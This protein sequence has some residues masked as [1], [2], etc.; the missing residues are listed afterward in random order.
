VSFTVAP[1][2][3]LALVGH[4]GA[5]KTTVVSL[6]L[7]FYDP[8]RGTI[9]IDGVDVRD[10]PVAELRATLAYVQQDIFLFAGDVASNIRL[11]MPLSDDDVARAAA[12]VGADR[13]IRRLPAGY[14]QE[15][16]ERGASVSVGERQLL[17][18][19]RAIAADPAL[20]VL[21]EATSAVDSELEAHIQLALAELMQGRTTI[22]IAHRLSTIV[23]ATEILVLHHGEVRERGTHASL[24]AAGGLYERLYRLQAGEL[25]R[26]ARGAA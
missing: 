4:T 24:L 21:D 26:P 18:F 14:K 22:A 19:A 12:R 23:A 16:G 8:Q 10:L 2:A 6:L 7:R 5:G 1:G 9:C 17:S 13:V 11:A 15:L 25:E 3:T 20:L